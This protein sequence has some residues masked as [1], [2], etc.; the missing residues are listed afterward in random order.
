[1]AIERSNMPESVKSLPCPTCAVPIDIV[2]AEWCQCLSKSLSV[3]CPS[4]RACFC[5]VSPFPKRDQWTPVL[6]E[7]IERQTAEKFRRALTA[8]SG[9]SSEDLAVLIVDD[10]EEIRLIAQYSVQQLGYRTLT[11]SNAEEALSIVKQW[12]PDIVLT[13][14]LMPKIDGRELCRLIKMIDTSIKVI[15]MSSLYTSARYR[16]EA[17]HMFKADEYLIKPINFDTL[18]QVLENVSQEAA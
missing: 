18:R 17:M 7:L 15:I 1:M 3:I 13:D 11:A 14:A 10:D 6:Q 2:G 8:S 9:A 4:C 5:K 12:G 16:I